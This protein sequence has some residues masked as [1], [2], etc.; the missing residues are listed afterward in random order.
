MERGPGTC[1]ESIESAHEF[2]A[3]LSEVVND[4]KQTIDAEMGHAQAGPVRRTAALKIARYNLDKLEVHLDRS[5][6]ILNDLR[7][8]RR[9]LFGERGSVLQPS[10]VAEP[11]VEPPSTVFVPAPLARVA[12][13]KTTRKIAPAA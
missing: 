13:I 9:L 7:S 12:R 10:V 2:L 8:L 4:A 1:F 11:V 3:L 6:R 5:V